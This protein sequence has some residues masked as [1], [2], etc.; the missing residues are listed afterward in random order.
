M[1][2]QI[3]FIP[4]NAF[5]KVSVEGRQRRLYF[6]DVRTYKKVPKRHPPPIPQF[7]GTV[8]WGKSANASCGQNY[9]QELSLKSGNC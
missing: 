9:V 4:E 2:Y 1:K 3:N 8:D 7:T 5:L 6:K